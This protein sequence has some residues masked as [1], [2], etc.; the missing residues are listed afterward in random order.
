ME[1]FSFIWNEGLV[2]PLMN[3]L[4]LFYGLLFGNLG[5]SILAITLITRLVLYPLTIKQLR[6]TRAMT[7]LQPKM[8]E[9]QERYKNDKTRLQR[10]QMKLFKEAGVNPLG[11]LGP[12][13]LQLPIFIALFYALRNVLA[14][15]PES[16]VSLSQNLYA[17]LP[18]GNGAAP[19]EQAFLGMDL[20]AL[21]SANPSG[22]AFI[23]PLVVGGSTWLVQKA[24]TTPSVDPQQQSTQRM[25]Q[26]MMPIMLGFF[27]L[28]FPA[29]LAVYWI[30]SNLVSLVL[31]IRTMGGLGGLAPATSP[32]AAPTPAVE[33]TVVRAGE[34]SAEGGA[35]VGGFLKKVFLGTQPAAGPRAEAGATDPEEGSD[36]SAPPARPASAERS[37]QDGG[38]RNDG[39]DRRGGR[40]KSTRSTRRGPRRRGG[41]RPR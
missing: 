37:V 21:V 7:Q 31:Q 5:L 22:Y 17:G 20:G 39:Q 28:S 8:K 13:F 15:T 32:A 33:G 6:S 40:P 23:L 14:D 1:I 3:G 4:V 2:R 41:R 30:A 10:E 16:L 34:A 27:T 18:F 36:E 26:W 38:N 11:C 19:I 24:T 9:M 12:I 25:L 29:G 35:G